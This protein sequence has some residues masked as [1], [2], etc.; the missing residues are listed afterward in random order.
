MALS[1][2]VVARDVVVHPVSTDEILANPGMGWQTFGCFAGDDK[3]LAGLPSASAYF[4]FYWSEL[5]PVEGKIEFTV[6][7][8]ALASARRAGQKLMFR[9]MCAGTDDVE[10]Y[11]P[12]WLRDNGC[13][14]FFYK[15]GNAGRQYWV[16]DMADQK[17]LDAH[18]WL[19]RELGARYDGHPDLDVLDIGTIGL[20]AEWHMSGTGVEM[21]PVEIQ[22]K[23][24]AAWCA[25]FPKTPKVAQIGSDESLKL[26]PKYRLG[27]RADCLG[28]MGGFSKNWNHMRDAYP[29]SVG[30]Y[31][32]SGLWKTAPVAFESCWDMRKWAEEKWDIRGIFDWALSVHASYINN[33]SAPIPEGTRGEVE[34]V[35]RRLGY[36]LV[37]KRLVH[38]REV[39]RGEDFTVRMEWENAGVA[40]P[41][42]DS[43]VALRL[44]APGRTPVVAVGSPVKGW[45]PGGHEIRET[46]RVSSGTPAGEYALAVAVTEGD[47]A[48]PVIRLAI[49]GRG[50]D[51]WYPLGG[52]T[53]R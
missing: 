17:F 27:W 49:T 51:G 45:L 18:L 41:Y 7:D 16:P 42:R 4:R 20:W 25:A 1:S 34:R 6:M 36:R 22:H 29:Q 37:L 32:T 28:D 23:I 15:Y 13:R 50:A 12:K 8:T 10:M 19:I 47:P 2:T 31:G 26:A 43:R 48:I 3:S 21:P 24:I 33:K 52:I 38:P 39:K 14:G 11:V 35:L 40:P 30:K 5:E 53:V 9:V 46:V 44:S